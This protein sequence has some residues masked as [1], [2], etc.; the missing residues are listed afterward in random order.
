MKKPIE[1]QRD[2][3]FRRA[4]KNWTKKVAVVPAASDDDHDNG[5]DHNGHDDHSD[6]D[7]E[8]QKLAKNCNNVSS[9]VKL[10]RWEREHKNC[11]NLRPLLKHLNFAEIQEGT[12]I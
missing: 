7:D 8:I 3:K 5:D 10:G 12:T 1:L 2:A 11:C 6:Y 4:A 9:K